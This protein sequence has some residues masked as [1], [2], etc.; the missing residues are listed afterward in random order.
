VRIFLDANIIFSAAKSDGAIRQL[1]RLLFEKGHELVADD[2]VLE[3]ARRNLAAKYASDE[4]SVKACFRVFSLP[5]SAPLPETLVL[6][7]K[8]RPVLASAIALRCDT[9][10]TGYSM[11]LGHLLGIAIEGITIYSPRLLAELLI[12]P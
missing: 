9:L 8:D 4:S 10:L 11:H 6:V 3:E 5:K 12:V 7:E 1:L 2:F